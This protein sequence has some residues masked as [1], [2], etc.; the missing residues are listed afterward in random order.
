MT[1][2][3]CHI[4]SHYSRREHF[5]LQI[6]HP[7][8]S[9]LLHCCNGSV[10]WRN[11]R[12]NIKVTTEAERSQLYGAALAEDEAV[13]VQPAA[14]PRFGE[15]R[16]GFAFIRSSRVR[17]HDEAVRAKPERKPETLPR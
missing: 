9:M 4:S 2:N 13:I 5:V 17:T 6:V 15:G 14:R 16:T 8:S 1:P 10:A 3:V 11:L 12:E 7:A